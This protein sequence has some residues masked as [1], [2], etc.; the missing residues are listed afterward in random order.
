MC[1]VAAIVVVPA[2]R[3]ARANCSE[4]S[5]PGRMWLWRSITGR[6]EG[7][8]SFGRVPRP[9]E[10]IADLQDAPITVLLLGAVTVLGVLAA[11]SA[12]YPVTAWGPGGLVLLALLLIALLALPHQLQAAPR[13]TLAAGGLLLA[14]VLWSYGSILWADDQ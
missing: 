4:P 2:A 3:A 9:R 7:R 11:S 8:G 14:Y 1:G 10:V 5:I 6:S 12:G 13:A